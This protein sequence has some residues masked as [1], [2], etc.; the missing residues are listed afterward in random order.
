MNIFI[1]GI[2]NF[3][4]KAIAEEFIRNGHQV[5]GSSRSA[6]KNLAFD[7]KSHEKIDLENIKINSE[8]FRNVDIL[9]H[10]AWDYQQNETSLKGTKN[11]Y[12]HAKKSGVSRQL[13]ISSYSAREDSISGYGRAKFE[14]E[15]FFRSEGQYICRPGLVLGKGG[16][17]IKLKEL[18]S[19]YPVIPVIDKTS[20]LT[21]IIEAGTLA[22]A[23]YQQ[24]EKSDPQLI[25][26]F[27]YKTPV[28]IYTL[29]QEI[30]SLSFKTRVFINTPIVL[31][32]LV[33]KIFNILRIPFPITLDNLKGLKQNQEQ[34]HESN[35]DILLDLSVFNTR[36]LLE[37]V[38]YQQ[39][40]T[41][42]A[43]FLYRA[44]FNKRPSESL[45]KRFLL[46]HN[47]MFL[48]PDLAQ[49]STLNKIIN[50]KLDAEAIELS[51][52][53]K[54]N[55]EKKHLITQKLHTISYL[56][57]FESQHF[58]DYVNETDNLLIGF[59]SGINMVLRTIAK[60]QKGNRL[61]KRY[62]LV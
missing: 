29:V 54:Y 6:P 23:I 35:L 51:F 17:F 39:S 21:P 11:L 58:E 13:L 44:L 16:L 26:N 42:E 49:Q 40:L 33:V 12:E 55:G 28:L 2:S 30:A 24:L 1:T 50:L 18:I 8:T 4:A 57:E 9:I 15:N 41:E 47:S 61:I 32:I 38:F 46:S 14:L 19:K 3:I 31:P 60:A 53:R 27:F 34:V 45:T 36:E 20:N 59:I 48:K 10:L 52:R 7:L 56:A 62:K 22:K 43:N 5:S 25:G 37:S